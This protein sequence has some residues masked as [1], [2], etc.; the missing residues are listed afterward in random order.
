MRTLLKRC[1]SKIAASVEP[2]RNH[3]CS[4]CGSRDT[5]HAT[6]WNAGWDSER[7]QAFTGSGWYC[8]DCY[9]IDWEEKSRKPAEEEER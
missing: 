4:S 5:T 7:R 8:R 2:L 9:Y 1:F 3:K 6:N